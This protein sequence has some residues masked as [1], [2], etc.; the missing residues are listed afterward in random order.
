MEKKGLGAIFAN[1]AI[2]GVLWYGGRLVISGEMSVGSLSSFLLYTLTV[3]VGIGMITAVW[4]DF[5]KA[6][7]S[8]HRIFELLDREP[9]VRFRGGI[10]PSTIHGHIRFK[11]VSFA[12]PARPDTMVLKN[13]NLRLEPGK[14]VA[15]VGK[16]GGGKYVSFYFIF[17]LF[18]S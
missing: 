4:G 1:I 5:M 16:S 13:L 18:Y 10:V 15:L 9:K 6:I 2:G 11:N 12:Y 14:V 7:G 8:S 17:N 3:A